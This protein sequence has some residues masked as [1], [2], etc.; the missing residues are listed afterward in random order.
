MRTTTD[1]LRILAEV[2]RGTGKRLAVV[3]AIAT[4]AAV[5][6]LLLVA[7]MPKQTGAVTQPNILFIMT[8]DQ[9]ESTLATMPNVQNL[10]KAKGRTFNNAFNAYP[11]CCPSRAIIQRGQ[12][13]H[14]TG[15]FGNSPDYGGGYETFDALDREK[16]TIATWM[17]AAGYR[18][19]HV[20]RYLNGFN[21]GSTPPPP[22]WDSWNVTRP[23]DVGETDT[24]TQANRAMAQLRDATPRAEPFYMQIGFPAPHAPNNYESQYAG[25]FAN[26]QVPRVPSFDEQDVSDKPRYIRQD[27]PPLAQQTNPAVS[28]AC[29]DNETNS[30][31]QNDCE[32]VRLLRNLQTVDRFVK[33]MTDYLASQGELSNTYIVYY[34]DNA[35]HWGEHRLDY[36]KLAPYETDAG[37]PLMIRGP[38]I[39]AGTTSTKLI[40]NQDIAPTFAQ[41]AGATT[42]PFVDGRSFLR[43]AD[44]ATT[45]DSPWRTALYAER[46]W[47][48]E[49]KLQSK[50]SPEYIPPWEAVREENLVY[51]R[52]GDDPWTTVNDAGFEEVY[53]LKADPYQLRNLAYYN[54]VPQATLDRLRSRLAN[55]RGCVAVACRTAEDK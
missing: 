51:I 7:S 24:A 55:L 48:P 54:E 31:Q 37:F 5:A 9:P 18:T 41:I 23:G 30:I 11:L 53:D 10:I 3:V 45:N 40:G 13:A 46:R 4:I 19:V 16:S 34:T 26:Q 49:W 42:P 50:T 27:K 47:K 36:G 22:G 32:Y 52:Y 17:D 35:N 20:G 1:Y 28:A 39:P 38:N 15:V 2:F 44:S 33:N 25:M 29:R 43:V 21:Y 12:Y 8:D 14:N 6:S